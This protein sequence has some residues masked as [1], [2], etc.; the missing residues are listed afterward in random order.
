MV[1][2]ASA[3]SRQIRFNYLH[4][5]LFHLSLIIP[6][7]LCA[8]CGGGSTM[9]PETLVPAS[10][11]VQ[12]DG[13]PVAGI[14][15]SFQPVSG[16]KAVGGYWAVTDDDGKFTVRQHASKPGIPPGEYE[17]RLSRLVKADG[18]P[19]EEDESPTMVQAIESISQ[20]YSDPSR[21]GLHNRVTV[22][23]KG[24]ESMDFKVSSIPMKKT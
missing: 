12:L 2:V 11:R 24:N 5:G 6:L 19:L 7:T 1:N 8:G 10:G 16:T 13:K 23:E 15:L 22:S 9:K 18:T 14:R 17:V 20:M 4:G 21:A 3:L